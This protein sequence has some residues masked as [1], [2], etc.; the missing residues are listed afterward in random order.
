MSTKLL[1]SPSVSV[2]RRLTET[3]DFVWPTAAAIWNLRWQVAGLVGTRPQITESELIGRFVEGS[4]VRGANLRRACLETSWENQQEQFA[5][6]LLFELCALYETWCELITSALSLPPGAAK[7][8]QFPTVIDS[9]GQTKGAGQI[10]QLIPANPSP[11]LAAALSPALVDN[12]KNSYAHLSTLLVCFRYFKELRNSLVHG[13]T[14]ALQKLQVAELAYAAQTATT[15]GLTQRPEYI[16]LAVGGAATP[17]LRG[18][19]GFGEVVLRLVTTFDIALAPTTFGEKAF[20]AR[21]T[22]THG[23]V[24]MQVPASSQ[25]RAARIKVLVRE[26]GLPP[27]VTTPAFTNWLK[28]EGL[29]A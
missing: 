1:Y 7:Q 21:W 29:I 3:F 25:H 2:S 15:L 13:S 16:A 14:Q 5:K 4:G 20:V 28:A 10:L 24:A 11:R 12:K 17:S 26:I 27:P 19:V 18:V 9:S 6:F 23:S 22:Q 8:L